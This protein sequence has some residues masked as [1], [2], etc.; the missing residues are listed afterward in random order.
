MAAVMKFNFKLFEKFAAKAYRQIENPSYT[1]NDALSVFQRYFE[2]YENAFGAAHPCISVAQI[3]KLIE[4]MPTICYGYNQFIDLEAADYF[5]MI[6]QHFLTQY[7]ACD[8]HI[9][10]FFS[11]DIRRFRYYET[12]KLTT[13]N[14]HFRK[15]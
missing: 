11:G 14:S 12:F 2:E 15:E 3:R 13:R 7:R 9:N 10:H 1:L 4:A 5:I 6:K 8:Y